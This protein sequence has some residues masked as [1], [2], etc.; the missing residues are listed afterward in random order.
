MSQAG[1]FDNGSSLPDIETLTGNSGGAV[2]PDAAFN[3]NILGDGTIITVVG[4]PG[5][6]TLTIT[7]AA[8]IAT[9]YVTDSGTAIPVGNILNVLGGDNISTSG[10]GDTVTVAVS[11][12]TDN[13]VQV[14]NASG[15]LTSLTV[16][17]NGQVLLGATGADAAFANL[18]STDGT[19]TFTLGANSLDLA[20]SGVA[21]GAILTITGDSGGAIAPDGVGNF[22]FTGGSTGL[23]F[24][25]SVDTQTVGGILVVLNGGTGRANQTE[26]AVI[27]GGTTTTAPQQSIASVG[28]SGQVLTSNGAAAL[29][30]FQSGAPSGS[31]NSIT[32][33]VFTSTGTYTPTSGMEFCTVEVQGGGGGG[34]GAAASGVGTLSVGAGGG[35]GGYARET[36]TA[37]TIGASQTVTIGAAGAG[38]T[39]GDNAG[40]TGGTTSLGTLLTGTGGVGG[41][42]GGTAAIIVARFGGVGGTGTG[43]DFNINGQPGGAGFGNFLVSNPVSMSGIGGS[44]HLGGGGVQAIIVGGASDEGNSAGTHGGG[45]SGAYSAASSTAK[46]GGPGTVGILIVTEYISS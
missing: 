16:G 2:G 14:G 7:P 38:G 11:G 6:N 46:A 20:A 29:P 15:S 8:T 19:V 45:G 36:L 37:A 33:Q 22:N 12:T 39:A 13:S 32:V 1:A 10:A 4:D 9:S 30:T 21:L 27:C 25:G 43:G 42:G 5:T 31:F 24:A 18:T 44:S 34:G 35:G 41:T 3:T 23:T 40:T 26:F 17:T 28:T